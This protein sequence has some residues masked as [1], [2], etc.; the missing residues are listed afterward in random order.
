MVEMIRERIAVIK[1]RLRRAEEN[2]DEMMVQYW[3]GNL[4]ALY[5]CLVILEKSKPE[6]PAVNRQIDDLEEAKEWGTNK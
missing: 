5:S 1:T 3:Y 2:A 6:W 4:D